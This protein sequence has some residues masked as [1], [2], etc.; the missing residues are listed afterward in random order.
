MALGQPSSALIMTL[1]L[2]ARAEVRLGGRTIRLGSAQ[3]QEHAAFVSVS[4]LDYDGR[5]DEHKAALN[6]L[7]VTGGLEM[8]TASDAPGAVGLGGGAARRV[9]MLAAL[10]HCRRESYD[11]AELARLARSLQEEELRQ[12]ANPLDA[13]AVVCGGVVVVSLTGGEASARPVAL[14]GGGRD[15]AARTVLVPLDRSRAGG[16]RRPSVLQALAARDPETVAAVRALDD[17][18]EPAAGALE[19]GDWKVLAAVYDETWTVQRRLDPVIA[20]PP[21]RALQDRLRAAGALAWKATSGSRGAALLVLCDPDRRETVAAAA[22]ESG[23]PALSAAP[24]PG[25]RVWE[26][27]NG[28]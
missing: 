10:A 17:L 13:W 8:L 24:G 19:S 21:G 15:V 4:D 20:A 23:C 12:P 6:M 25:L 22:R 27:P 5:L 1:A 16:L 7:P 28:G 18:V 9:A 14:V 3:P 26:E 11:G 2:A